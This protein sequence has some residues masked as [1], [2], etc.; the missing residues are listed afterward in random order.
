MAYES[1]NEPVGHYTV[2]V[3][4]VYV[5]PEHT[6]GMGSSIKVYPRTTEEELSV[7]VRAEDQDDAI[8]KAI[9]QL[10]TAR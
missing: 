4:V 7:T 3:K 5:K 8:S 6:S 2:Q 10:E 9:A 1:K